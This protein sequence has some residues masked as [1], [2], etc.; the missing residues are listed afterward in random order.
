[1]AKT[2]KTD[3]TKGWKIIFR[4]LIQ[5]RKEVI[6][7]SILGVVSA[8]ANASVP[9]IVGKFF[10]SVLN[11]SLVIAHPIEIPV[12]AGLLILWAF[13]QIIANVTDWIND[14]ERRRIGT[15][16]H[17]E[18]PA[19]AVAHL[20]RVPISFHKE[21]K[22][23]VVWDR[24]VRAG[25]SIATIIE[26]VVINLAP[27][28][29]GIII[30]IAISFFINP[31]LAL[32]IV[33][34]MCVY[35]FLLIKIVSPIALFQRKGNK[36]WNEAFGHGYDALANVQT[37]KQA[38]AESYETARVSRKFIDIAA[39]LWFKV[40][41]IWSGIGF[42]QRMVIALTQLSVFVVSVYF[43]KA[44]EITIG[45]LIALNGYAGLVFGPLVV[46]GYNW[47]IIQNG[48]VAIERAERM[49]QVPMEA[50][51]NNR[52]HMIESI[53][54]GIEFSNVSF[55][56]KKGTEVL[57]DVNFKV[58][59]GEVIALVGES[60]AGKSTLIDL[61]SGYHYPAKGTVYIDGHDTRNINLEF[62][63]QSI[64]I[65]P[66]EVVLFNDSIKTNL[67]YGN[68]NATH[69]EIKKAVQDAYAASFIE[70]FPKKYD[71]LVGERGVKLSVGQKQRVAIARAILR[72]PK[73]LILDE[74]TS[75]LD[76]QTER[77]ITESLERLMKGRTTFIIAHRLSTVRKANRIFVLKDGRI[78]EEGSHDELM[79]IESGV[80]RHIYE[81]HVGLR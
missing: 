21:R 14:K 13:V 67:R 79:R 41:K 31:S 18:Y 5:Y 15:F 22:M 38:T 57:K 45:E 35:I 63:R 74:P 27:Q 11:P 81:L 72:N 73:I 55:A 48:L 70:K 3:F 59:P 32:I 23:G 61:I 26:Q 33:A 9:Y 78:A 50:Y 49:L 76:P 62:L 1:M 16:L 47:Q 34:G 25:N 66:Q 17:A 29:L 77:V 64:A 4:Y 40:E 37:I 43:I 52:R 24:I 36:A 6:L 20:L 2:N 12:W 68:L 19:H 80:Y 53:Q 7:L 8:F 10:D 56:Y 46:I 44:G 39:R 60:G 42:Y 65:V 54:G 58:N 69:T 51:R 28:L 71:Q 75:A 30:G